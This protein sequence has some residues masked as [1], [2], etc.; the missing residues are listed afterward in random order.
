[1]SSSKEGILCFG[2]RPCQAKDDE[3]VIS[4]GS[5]HGRISLVIKVLRIMEWTTNL[6][7]PQMLQI[8]VS[9]Y[10]ARTSWDSKH[11]LGDM[12]VLQTNHWNRCQQ[13][14]SATQPVQWYIPWTGN[15]IQITGNRCS[16]RCVRGIYRMG[17]NVCG[18]VL[19]HPSTSCSTSC[20]SVKYAV[21]AS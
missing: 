8:L 5:L 15:N 2:V 3:K 4:N 10:R 1:M 11:N 6:N 12:I 17:L 7:V 9:H 18:F 14:V 13:G 21:E 19:N 20:R 16:H